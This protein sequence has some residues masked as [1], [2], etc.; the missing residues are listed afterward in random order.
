MK[1]MESVNY[2]ATDLRECGNFEQYKQMT[3]R[4]FGKG[5]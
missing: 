1:I 4:V 2:F 3:A 5:I